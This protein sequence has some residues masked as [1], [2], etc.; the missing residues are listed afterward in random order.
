MKKKKITMLRQVLR[1]IIIAA[2]LLIAPQ[3]FSQS[4]PT[5]FKTIETGFNN[6]PDSVRIAVYWY[7]M[8]DNIS[9]EGVQRDLEA[10]KKAGITRAYIGIIGGQGVPYGKTKIFTPEWWNVLHAALKKATELNITIGMFNSPGWSQS[11]GPWIKPSQSMRYLAAVDTLINGGKTIKMILPTVKPFAAKWEDAEQISKTFM[12][13][14][15]K[16]EDVKI[17]AYPAIDKGKVLE[18]TWKVAKKNGETFTLEMPFESKLQAKSLIIKGDGYLNS[19]AELYEKDGDNYKFIKKI[20]VARTNLHA[21]AGFYPD[22]P[23]VISMPEAGGSDYRLVFGKDGDCNVS[24]TLTSVPKEERYA[25]KSLAK[26]FPGSNPLFG[27]YMWEKQPDVNPSF[28]IDPEKVLDLTQYVKDGVLTWK[29]PSGKWVVSRTAMFTTGVSNGPTTPE[30]R[31]LEVDKMNKKHVAEHFDAYIGNVLKNI[32]E[33]DRKT[34]KIVVA[35]SYETGGQNWTDDMIDIFKSTYHY[36]PLPYLPVLSGAVVGSPD[37]SDR[38]LWDLRRLIADKI[39][40]DYVGGLREASHKHGMTSWLENYGHWG[41]PAEFMQYG[42]QSDE[43]GGEFWTEGLGGLEVKDAAS[44][45]HVYGKHRVWAESCTA[46]GDA[47]GRYPNYLKQRIDNYFTIGV[48]STLLHV[49]IE[50]PTEDKQPGLNAWFGTEFN[51]HNTWFSQMGTFTSYLRRVNYMLQ[52]GNYVADVAYYI[53]EDAPKMAGETTPELPQGYSSDYINAEALMKYASVKDNKLTLQSGMQYKVLVLPP[54]KTMRPEVLS[55]IAELV[56]QGLTIVGQAPEESPSLQDYPKADENVKLLAA[57]MWG[58]P[59]KAMNEYGKG[60]VYSSA[61]L[62]DLLMNMGTL[63]DFDAGEKNKSSVPFIHRTM[64][65][66]DIYF[67]SNQTN[68]TLTL[69]PKFRVAGKI[70]EYWMPTTGELRTL[71][72]FSCDGTLTTVPLTLQPSESAFVVFRQNGEPSATAVSNFPEGKVL[73]ALAGPWT[74]NFIKDNKTVTM[75]TL[76][77]WTKFTEPQIR[78][79][80]GDA[81]YTTSFKYKGKSKNDVYLDLGNVMVMATVKINGKDAGG[82]WTAPYRLNISQYLKKGNNLVEV[83]VVNNWKNRMIGDMNLP[84][85]ERTTSVTTNPWSKDTPLQS[86]GL[87]GPACIEEI[88][89]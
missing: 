67:I 58:S 14:R 36:D 19:T 75:K 8:S 77:D 62:K 22:A 88:Q 47:F 84:E 63:P 15:T 80:S 81:V 56:K 65:D 10:M 61:N 37:K 33:A 64:A 39:A 31:G 21:Q 46:N 7:W 45:A 24:V 17:I 57:E 34:F 87:L 32:P 52:Q 55:K 25:E 30:A 23:I 3:A 41:Y 68:D 38:F 85:S 5:T 9:V 86:S 79:Y 50:Q 16:G 4:A 1:A 49:Y 59:S 18:K 54:Q 40:Y 78:Y 83:T 53:G 29:A 43:I 12:D 82:V 74:V 11:G 48:N 44:C 13:E 20:T 26:M 51:R 69:A 72:N 35:D 27:D 70:P 71:G 42:G 66:G 73:N 2:N 6:V 89:Y 76:Q 60:K 28:C